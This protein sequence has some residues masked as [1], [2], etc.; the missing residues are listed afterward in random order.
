M[1]KGPLRESLIPY[2]LIP[3]DSF[4]GTL[5]AAA[6]TMNTAPAATTPPQKPTI[7]LT[8]ATASEGASRTARA[9]A[10]PAQKTAT[11]P[12]AAAAREGVKRLGES[13][14]VVPCLIEIISGHVLTGF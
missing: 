13:V 4:N 5:L 9:A 8:T 7:P 11:L 1:L 10:T 2:W 3:H 12:I 6:N 14:A